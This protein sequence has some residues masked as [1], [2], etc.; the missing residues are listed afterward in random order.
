[1]SLTAFAEERIQIGVDIGTA[2][3]PEFQTTIVVNGGGWERRNVY[4]SAARGRWQLGDRTVNRAETEYLS[5]FFRQRRGRAVG[6]RFKDWADWKTVD[7]ALAAPDGTPAGQLIKTYGMGADE[8]VRKITKPVAGSV[9]FMRNGASYAGVTV[10]SKTGAVVF[11]SLESHGIGYTGVTLGN[12]TVIET[13]HAS[14]ITYS[15]GDLVYVDGIAGTVELNGAAWAVTAID[16]NANTI[17]LDVDSTSFT[18]WT[19]GGSIDKYPQPTDAITWSGE[20]DVPVRFD[21]DR[22]QLEFIAYRESDG[23]ALYTLSG[24]PIVELRL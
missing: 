19:G 10:D 1:M 6:F 22:L 20:F 14:A 17:S 9:S 21:T 4:W 12:P 8:Y 2:G 23:E 7:E 13:D 5:G 24:L 15:P 18:P 3:G 11:V 16:T